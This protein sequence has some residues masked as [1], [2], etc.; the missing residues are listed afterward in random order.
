ML[1]TCPWPLLKLELCNSEGNQNTSSMKLHQAEMWFYKHGGS[2]MGFASM[3]FGCG[4][5][6]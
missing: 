1:K 2:F 4:G 6:K 5:K 3:G